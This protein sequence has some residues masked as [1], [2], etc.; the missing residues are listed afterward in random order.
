MLRVLLSH[1]VKLGLNKTRNQSPK[2]YRKLW[3]LSIPKK[4]LLML[5]K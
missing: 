2:L 5:L 3:V 4:P 1:L